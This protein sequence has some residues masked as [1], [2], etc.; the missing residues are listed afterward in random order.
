MFI[1]LLEN[2]SKYIFKR[3][4]ILFFTVTTSNK[5][6]IILIMLACKYVCRYLTCEMIPYQ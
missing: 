1:N 3:I 2:V 4:F 6:E 5:S